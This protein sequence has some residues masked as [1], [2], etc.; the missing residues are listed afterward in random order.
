MFVFSIRAGMVGM[1]I[2]I[3]KYCVINILGKKNSPP[4]A[5]KISI[6]GLVMQIPLVFASMPCQVL[7]LSYPFIMTQ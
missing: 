1:R 5:K 7:K 4:Q 2:Q 6:Y 3:H